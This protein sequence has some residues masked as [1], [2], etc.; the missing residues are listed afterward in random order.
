ML[1][2][3]V[4]Y[5]VGF[6]AELAAI[7]E[8]SGVILWQRE[9]SSYAG[10]DAD[11]RQVYVTDDQDSIWA[12]DAA[13]GATLWQQKQLHA[14][15]LSAPAIVTSE[16]L[17]V[18]D[19]EGYLHF[20]AADDGRMLARVRVGSDGIRAKPLVVDDVIYVLNDNGRLAALR[21]TRHES[22]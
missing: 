9:L 18:G 5:G 8:A 19:L 15:R 14:R 11:W 3:G 7:S 16:Y 6:Q 17:V 2:E 20:L 13:N 21:P 10:L 1:V 12:L 22:E 4:V